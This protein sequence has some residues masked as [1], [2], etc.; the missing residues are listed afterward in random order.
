[1]MPR[2]KIAYPNL[3]AEMARNGI[4]IQDIADAIGIARETV[5]AKL[6]CKRPL[7]LNE[8]FTI[9]D[10]FFPG[11]DVRILFQSK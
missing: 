7:H 8:A 6:S 9:V 1:M 5:G 4:S 2:D 11:N 3:R 10:K